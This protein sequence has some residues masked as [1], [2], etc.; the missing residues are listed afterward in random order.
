[1]RL[2]IS[3][4][5]LCLRLRLRLRLRCVCFGYLLDL[6]HVV[7]CLDVEPAH[8]LRFRLWLLL[9]LSPWLRL[10]LRLRLRCVCFGNLLDLFTCSALFGC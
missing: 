7:L 9:L 1:M 8:L 10:R 2:C 4:P 3:S 6:L 5:R